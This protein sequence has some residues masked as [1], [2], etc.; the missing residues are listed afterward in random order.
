MAHI[1]AHSDDGP[2]ADASYPKESRAEYENLILLCPTHHTEVDKQPNTYTV[3]DLRSWKTD[4]EAWVRT[5]LA[6][7]MPQVGFAELEVVVKGAFAAPGAP[8]ERFS[9]TPA[10][11]KLAKNRLTDRVHKLLLMGYA[12]APEVGRFVEHMIVVDSE[13]PERMRAGFAEHYDRLR[14]GG[15]D[16]DDLFMAL[17]EF[18]CGG[19]T[20]QLRHAAA[21]AVLGY[22]F[23]KCE[24]FEP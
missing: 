16:G 14:E 3:A 10:I 7:E 4:H 2:R 24:V 13:F 12:G 6:R 8:S 1:V 22:L 11:E 20:D 5:R 19:S 18:A 21:L 23:M 17:Y 9:A 15:L